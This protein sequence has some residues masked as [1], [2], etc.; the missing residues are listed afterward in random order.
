FALGATDT[1]MVA[2]ALVGATTA[3]WLAETVGSR[4]VFVVFAVVAAILVVA[5]PESRRIEQRV[6]LQAAVHV[7]S[8][9]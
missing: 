3:P 7:T 9:S 5:M 4:L 2:G 8:L 1:V 6:A